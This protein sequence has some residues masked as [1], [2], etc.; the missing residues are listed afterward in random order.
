MGMRLYLIPSF[1]FSPVITS[2]G[3]YIDRQGVTTPGHFMTGS[4]GRSSPWTTY[5]NHTY[6]VFNSGYVIRNIDYDY[7]YVDWDSCGA[8]RTLIL[9]VI[10]L[11]VYVI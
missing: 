4:C 6:G 11:I 7:F 9:V 5:D 3:C 10:A 8:L 2:L 1:Y